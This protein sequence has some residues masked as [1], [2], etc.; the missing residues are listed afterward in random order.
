M[1]NV[2]IDIET[3]DLKPTAVVLSIGAVQFNP[4][5]DEL[6]EEFYH[7]FNIDAQIN[8]GRTVSGSTIRWW[9]RQDDGARREILKDP[10]PLVLGLLNFKTWLP[11]D[12]VIWSHGSFDINVL[13]HCFSYNNPWHYRNV[14]DARTL[15]TTLSDLEIEVK[16][17]DDVGTKHNAL[18][19]AVFQARSVQNIYKALF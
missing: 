19:D 12:V 17:P 5:T 15:L 6:G 2:M 4:F 13:E 3:F 10:E 16:Q 9:L 7:R 18:D 1:Q 11:K 14:R 8:E